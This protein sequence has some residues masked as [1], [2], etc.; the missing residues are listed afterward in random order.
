MLLIN[1][2][3]NLILTWSTN[4]VISNAAA[5]QETTFATTDTKLY[6]L[7]AT[8]SV[9]D[10]A[11]LLQQLKSWFKR[12]TKC[13]K[14]QSKT[15]TQAPNRY[16]DHLIDRSFQGV[17]R[18]FVS[19]FDV[20]ANRLGH[21]RYYLPTA[22]VEDYN[23]MIDGKNFFDQSIKNDIKHSKIFEKFQLVKE[24]I[25]QLVAC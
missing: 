20:N 22:K 9:Q 5:N 8:L 19:K 15:S 7:V 3:I 17:K 10:N 4:C 14:Y 6:V 16:F 12:T 11:K 25:T 2:E 24:M 13:N 23:V 18:L 1:C 21:S